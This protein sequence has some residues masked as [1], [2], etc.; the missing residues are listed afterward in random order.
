[1]KIKYIIPA[2]IAVVAAMFIGCSENND[3][4]Y[5]GEIRVSQSYVSIPAAGG[6]SSISVTA[7]GSWS[8]KTDLSYSKWLTINPAQ[9]GAGTTTISFSAHAAS[10]S[11]TATVVLECE[12]KTQEINVQQ[13]TEKVE[14]PI[15][16]CAQI[17]AGEDG[18]TFRAK[19]TCT[20]I[21]NTTYG[22]WYLNDGTGD[23][24]IYGTLDAKG[25]E[26]NFLSLGIEVGDIITVEGPKTT[27]NGTV[28]LVNVTVLNIEKSLIKADSIMIGGK[29]GDTLPLEGGDFEV[30]LTNKANGIS[31]DI[32]ADAQ[33]WLS[34]LGIQSSG[35]S[36][37]VKFRAAANTG[38]DRSTTLT[39][40]TND[41]KKTY[42]SQA[43]INQKG[44]I[45]EGPVSDF[46]AAAVGD[47]QFRLTGV[48]T[49]LYASDKQGK[50]FYIADYSGKT[51]IYRAEGFIEAGAK[52]GD[53]VTV[54]GKRGAYKDS[55]Q[56][57]SGTFEETKYSVKEVSIADFRNVADN[58]EAYYLITGTI[59]EATESGTKNDVTQ[60][61]N[62]NLT[63]DSGSV[64]VYG[65]LKG[66]GGAKG[67][68]GDLGLTWGDKLTIIAYKTTYK[69]LVEAVG[70]Y[71][72]HEKAQ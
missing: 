5:L 57:V 3:P 21:A 58:K 48:I 36:S 55:P 71:L 67:Q 10:A 18:K 35:T 42:S 39:F 20:A 59:S 63:D 30:M 14:L 43:T 70:V 68:F 34:V 66:W 46:L 41:G 1:M 24:Y 15:S 17:V 56:M 9:G 32:P 72:S 38:G 69:G 54:V 25:A 61:G 23:V 49:E 11:N 22:N 4:S 37:V 8:V 27:Y 2:F 6:A 19:G 50:S 16:T 29:K 26:K 7:T 12:G 13:I 51:L 40:T 64:Y 62:F 47:T 44:A 52:V 60:Y 65:V 33:S 53:V 31:I 28:E 45:I